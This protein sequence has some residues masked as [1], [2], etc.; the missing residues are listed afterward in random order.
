MATDIEQAKVTRLVDADQWFDPCMMLAGN[1]N[2]RWAQWATKY[3]FAGVALDGAKS[4]D[5]PKYGVITQFD[6][7]L[8]F[9]FTPGAPLNTAQLFFPTNNRNWIL[10]QRVATAL[11]QNGQNIS[12]DL[13]DVNIQVPPTTFIMETMPA[14]NVFGSGEWPHVMYFP[15]EWPAN[16]T[17]TVTATNRSGVTATLY[18]TFTFLQ[19]RQN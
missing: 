16:V 10:V 11:N 8:Q 4:T 7:K 3:L 13:F 6:R 19:V 5:W 12:L 9:D 18:L 15:E 14:S 17:R 2:E 1:G